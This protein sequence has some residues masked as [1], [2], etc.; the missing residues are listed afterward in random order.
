MA[1]RGAASHALV[2]LALAPG[3][4]PAAGAAVTAAGSRVGEVTSAALSARAGAIALAY[5]RRAQ[6]APGSALAV[7]GREARAARLPFVAPGSRAP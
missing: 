2:G 7:E 6:A 5:V 4:L 1:S 3:P